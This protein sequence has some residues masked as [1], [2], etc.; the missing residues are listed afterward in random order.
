VRQNGQPGKTIGHSPHSWRRSSPSFCTSTATCIAAFG[1]NPEE[2]C[3]RQWLCPRC[4]KQQD[5]THLHIISPCFRTRSSDG[6]RSPQ[7]VQPRLALLLARINPWQRVPR[8]DETVTMGKV[9]TNAQLREFAC[10]AIA[11]ELGALIHWEEA[12][13]FPALPQR[14]GRNRAP[15]A[16]VGWRHSLRFYPQVFARAGSPKAAHSHF[17][18]RIGFG[19]AKMV[20]RGYRPAFSS[21]ALPRTDDRLSSRNDD[22]AP[23]HPNSPNCQVRRQ[24]PLWGNGSRTAPRRGTAA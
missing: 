9:R 20:E 8:A 12:L 19:A 15:R 11:A 1:P 5:Q 22:M 4:S 2:R 21:A 23:F 13:Q 16:P 7:N 10:T 17:Q 14:F 6:V 3:V 18:C 24:L